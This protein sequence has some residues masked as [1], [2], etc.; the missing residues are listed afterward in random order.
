[1]LVQIPY[2]NEHL[3]NQDCIGVSML[4]A[5]GGSFGRGLRVGSALGTVSLDVQSSALEG[6]VSYIDWSQR[7]NGSLLQLR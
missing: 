2:R 5:T 6:S 1:M 7:R 3:A 4:R